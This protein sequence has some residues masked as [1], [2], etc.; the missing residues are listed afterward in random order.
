MKFS[1][2][3]ISKWL[4]AMALAGATTVAMAVPVV[5]GGFESGETGWSISGATIGTSTGN[6]IGSNSL[7]Y[8]GSDNGVG[9][10]SQGL[11]FQAGHEYALSFLVRR[12]TDDG[13]I[14]IG[15]EPSL[16]VT[17]GMSV[18]DLSDVDWE[19]SDLTDPGEIWWKYQVDLGDLLSGPLNL[20]FTF[21]GAGD[22]YLDQVDVQD[23]GCLI[24]S[25]HPNCAT[26]GGGNDVPEPG[27]LLLVGAALAGLGLVRRRKLA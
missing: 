9:T 26:N 16:T 22:A 20:T 13:A 24:G 21:R 10:A 18:L 23:D 27:S 11:T 5:N 8:S 15:N 19:L 4:G 6:A 14:S 7:F 2:N 3:S 17:L 25:T 12:S 1:L